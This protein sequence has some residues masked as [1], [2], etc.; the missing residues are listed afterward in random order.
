[1]DIWASDQCNNV[2]QESSNYS[3]LE[4]IHEELTRGSELQFLFPA[5]R[6]K[7]TKSLV[8][9]L[10]S[11]TGTDSGSQEIEEISSLLAA[12]PISYYLIRLPRD[13]QAYLSTLSSKSRQ[14]LRYYNRRFEAGGGVFETVLSADINESH[15][16]EL[17]ALHQKR[18]GVH[19]A[20]LGA[21]SVEFHKEMALGLA[22]QGYLSLF[23]AKI[24]GNRIAGMSCIDINGRRE[25]Y[26]TG[27]D[28]A[29]KS[30]RIGRVLYMESIYDA[31]SRGFSVYDL[32]YGADQYKTDFTHMGVRTISHFLCKVGYTELVDPLFQGYEC[33]V[34]V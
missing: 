26:M 1:L 15:I 10:Q 3:I 4:R 16:D 13:S 11:L 25:A 18:W 17:L 8:I 21:G 29:M 31:I 28:P 2:Y 32:G 12:V 34:K 27:R 7:Y 33:M 24:G 5:T 22:R 30:L 14:N 19:S 23:F 9:G 20:L 6:N